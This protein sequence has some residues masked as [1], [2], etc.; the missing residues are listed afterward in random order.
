MAMGTRFSM[1]S[2]DTRPRPGACRKLTCGNVPRV[3]VDLVCAG[4]AFDDLIFGG[5]SEIPGPG[6]EIKTAT[7]VRTVGGGAVITAVAAAR[8]G[9]RVRVISGLSPDA[10]RLLRAER[11]AFKNVRARDEPIALS[12]AMSTATDRSF[13]T[14][15][16]M[17]PRLPARLTRVLASISARHVHLAFQ[18]KACRTW[19][20]IVNRLRSR[21]V[22]TSW[23]FG[24]NIDL[25]RDPDFEAL[26]ASTDYLFLNRDEALRYARHRTLERAAQFWAGHA[27]MAVIKLGAAGARV[28]SGSLD[29]S[30]AAPR[31]H[32]VDTTGA[33]DAFNGGFLY[34][35][36]AGQP[37]RAC[38]RL[39]NVVGARST[40]APGG[41]T[42][43]PG[44]RDI[45]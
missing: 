10:Q 34:A 17:N 32:V 13:V 26:T 38:L 42:A 2:D 40:R 29:L 24:W 16:G 1:T 41:I 8:L 12:V 23:D 45:R 44:G 7:F 14:F 35:M 36:L 6:R 22:S 19:I 20:P 21:G 15:D 25:P 39:G 5:L 11:V 3:A 43:L 4:D 31:V 37:L 28:V 18:P 9:A 30:V 27:R 33:G